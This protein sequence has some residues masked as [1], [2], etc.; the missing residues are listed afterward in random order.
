MLFYAQKGR[1][2]PGFWIFNMHTFP[3]LDVR[4]QLLLLLDLQNSPEIIPLEQL[5]F[6]TLYP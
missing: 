5:L 2:T 3:N 1:K 6:C 4:K